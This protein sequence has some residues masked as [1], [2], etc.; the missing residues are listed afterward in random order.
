MPNYVT[1]E[2][3]IS[4]AADVIQ[5]VPV[6]H[7]LAVAE[8]TLYYAK[9]QELV[10]EANL[11]K[12]TELIKTQKYDAA[13]FH[14]ALTNTFIYEST[15]FN[16]ADEIVTALHQ[17][18]TKLGDSDEVVRLFKRLRIQQASVKGFAAELKYASNSATLEAVTNE[19]KVDK[20]IDADVVDAFLNQCKY[21]NNAVGL[22]KSLRSWIDYA[23]AENSGKP[24]RILVKKGGSITSKLAEYITELSDKGINI[25]WDDLL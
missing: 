9:A 5:D 10:S 3:V 12:Y 13:F 8:D 2:K 11:T 21:S 22:T 25:S 7:Q 14:R 19:F 23:I 16:T 4:E 18:H 6:G 15:I 1:L 20:G 24:I 17:I